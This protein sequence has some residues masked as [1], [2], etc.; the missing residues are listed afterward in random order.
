MADL[1]RGHPADVLIALCLAMQTLTVPGRKRGGS[2]LAEGLEGK[3]ASPRNIPGLQIEREGQAGD[4]C[5]PR[6][7]VP[8]HAFR[9]CGPVPGRPHGRDGAGRP[10][11]CD[12]GSCVVQAGPV[13]NHLVLV[14]PHPSLLLSSLLKNI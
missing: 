11:R 14:W 4:A 3:R 6:V 12:G 8:V 9:L 1:C 7:G 10:R 13:F 2:G 5:A